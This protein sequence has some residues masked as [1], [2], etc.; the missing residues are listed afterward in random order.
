MIHFHCKQYIIQIQLFKFLFLQ[1][2]YTQ[3]DYLVLGPSTSAGKGNLINTQKQPNNKHKQEGYLSF[4]SCSK[5][6]Y[7]EVAVWS[8]IIDQPFLTNG[9]RFNCNTYTGCQRNAVKRNL[10]HIFIMY[11]YG[12]S[13]HISHHIIYNG[14]FSHKKAVVIRVCN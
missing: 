8:S 10:T 7:R 4:T 13:H 14:I 6:L 1:T 3:C 12:S 5:V 2:M 11:L 9:G